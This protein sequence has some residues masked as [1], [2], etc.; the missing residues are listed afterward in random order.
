MK[1]IRSV[2]FLNWS[3]PSMRKIKVVFSDEGVIFILASIVNGKKTYT[4]INVDDQEER[5][6]ATQIAKE[7]INWL[8]NL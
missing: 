6:L 4:L 2:H 5:K 3:I 7:N 1:R 8:H